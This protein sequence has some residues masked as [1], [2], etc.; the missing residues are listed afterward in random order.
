MAAFKVVFTDY[1]YSDINREIA[2][3]KEL[4]EVEIVDCTRVLKG[5]A[6][7]ED[8]VIRLAAGADALIVQFAPITRRVIESLDRC[9]IISRYA[10][11]LDN[12]DLGAARERGIAVANVPDYCIEEVSDT[13]L[14]HI[15]NCQ[16]KLSLADR[17]LHAGTWSYDRV[18]PM[19]RLANQTVGLVAFGH[20]ARRLAEKL[21]PYGNRILAYDP[22]AP[23][24]TGYDWVE[25][26]PLETLLARSDIISIHAPLTPETRHL[27]NRDRI[28]AMKE[29][30]VLVN[31]S[32]GG[33]IDEAA[34]EEGIQSG[35]IAMAGLDVLD[36]PDTAYARSPLC[37]YPDRVVITPHM[38]WY[39][40]EAIADLQAK[41]ARHVAEFLAG[42]PPL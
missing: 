32:R 34:L 39:S 11:G 35:K 2:I 12:I 41:A 22:F 16:R 14:A 42:K 23:N 21:R 19:R 31:T 13:A 6:K 5:G 20:I 3:L 29:G 28:A 36:G 40:E 10:I 18:K 7:T 25:A 38:G 9:R 8:D 24:M 15:L 1:Y 17:L 33:L 26:V 30:V 37:R 4:D 27:I